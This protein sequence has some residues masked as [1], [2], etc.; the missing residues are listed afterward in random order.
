MRWINISL[1][2]VCL[3]GTGYGQSRMENVQFFSR[4]LNAERSIY[5][6]LPN[7][8]DLANGARYPVIYFLHGAGFDPFLLML[9]ASLAKGYLD[10]FINQQII[11]PVIVVIPDG[12][13]PP[14]R[15]SFY[16]N[17]KLYGNFEDYIV[18]DLTEFID[19]N[20]QTLAAREKRFIIGHSMGG[21]GAMKLAIKHPDVYRGVA[22]H[23][24]PLDLTQVR[25]LIPEVLSENGGTPPYSYS[26]SAGTFTAFGFTMAGAFSPNR[27]RPPYYVDFPLDSSGGIVDSV[28]SKWLQHNPA[29]LAN[30]LSAENDLSIYF[31]CGT[32]DE[33]ML[34]PFN[35]AFADSLARLGRAFE[36]RSYPGDHTSQLPARVAISLAFIDSVMKASPVAVVEPNLSPQTITLYQNYPNPFNPS[37]TIAFSLPYSAEV[38]LS[39]YNALGQ[40]VESLLLEERLPAGDFSY[41]WH[42]K[43]LASGV[44]VYCLQADGLVQTKKLVLLR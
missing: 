13:A 9:F 18:Q 27:N 26:P 12:T 5:V 22:A 36:F 20:Y 11:I 44:Y 31:D 34:H 35:T 15:G 29:A 37:T 43:E 10:D 2:L 16:T 19:Q 42:P 33:L 6:Y 24:G 41:T 39:I 28:F 40:K 23:S 32:E 17:S 25:N 3:V 4:A 8:Y 7:G 14:Y 1:F 30:Q 38:T 21:Y